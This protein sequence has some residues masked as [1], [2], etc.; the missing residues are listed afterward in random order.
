MK[1]YYKWLETVLKRHGTNLQWYYLYQQWNEIDLNW[2]EI[3][4]K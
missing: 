4:Q 3:V 1:E 2:H